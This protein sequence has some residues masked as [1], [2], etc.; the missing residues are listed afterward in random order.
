MK[1]ADINTKILVLGGTGYYGRYIVRSLIEKGENVRVLSRNLENA[2][3]IL[4]E[5]PEIIEGDITSKEKVIE[6]LSGVKAIIFSISAFNKKTIKR[7]KEIERDSVLM[8]L[9]EANRMDIP[10]IVYISSYDIDRDII[11]SSKLSVGDIKIEIEEWLSKSDFNWT[12]IGVPPNI[13][14]YFMMIRGQTMTVPGGGYLPL[15]TVSPFDLGKI[16]AEATIRNDLSNKRFRATGS[17][18]FSFPVAAERISIE[19]GINIKHRKIPL[20]LLKLAAIITK[21]INPYIWHLLKYIR[22]FNNFPQD[23]VTQVPNDYRLLQETFNYES[24]T[25]E[26]HAKLWKDKIIKE[27]KENKN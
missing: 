20:F 26:M 21:P 9:E 11:E 8:A 24:T 5:K 22:L 7:I 23:L 2:K 6:S 18:A 12:V 1:A 13:E 17:E 4:G 14:I 27:K 16:V 3:K 19:T 15:P 10:R 25:L